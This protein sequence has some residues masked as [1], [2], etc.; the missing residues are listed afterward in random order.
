MESLLDVAPSEPTRSVLELT[1]RAISRVSKKRRSRLRS[2]IVAVGCYQGVH[3]IFV[4]Y[5]RVREVRYTPTGCT[6][7]SEFA[8]VHR[9]PDDSTR[10]DCIWWNPPSAISDHGLL[11]PPPSPRPSHAFILN[12]GSR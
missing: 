6:F 1:Q 11:T 2:A 8:F 4:Y 10:I 3:N 9:V 7:T 12:H 5:H